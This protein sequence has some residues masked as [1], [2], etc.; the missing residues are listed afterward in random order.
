MPL[1][2]A[3]LAL[4]CLTPDAPTLADAASV[5]AR[6]AAAEPDAGAKVFRRCAACHTADAKA[7]H[8]VGPPLW[9]VVGRPVAG[10]DGFRYSSALAEHGGAWDYGTLD[11]YLAD[12][13]GTV[14]GTRMAFPGLKKPSDRANLIAWLRLQADEPTA[15]PAADVEAVAS[16]RAT[17]G[18]AEEPAELALLPAGDGRQDV[19]ETC[20]SCHSLKL[21]VQQGL[22]AGRWDEIIDWM[23]EEQEMDEPEPAARDRIVAYLAEHY[24]VDR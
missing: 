8:K 16:A 23:V 19:F 9:N 1:A 15:L 5:A 17:A 3:L 14:P 13:R 18:S 21:V 11:A 24:G 20:S 4:A 6:L 22:P 12:P 2:A 10:V 7:R